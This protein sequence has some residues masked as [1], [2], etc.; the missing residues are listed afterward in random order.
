[1]RTPRRT[2]WPKV[3][4]IAVAGR[5]RVAIVVANYNTRRLIAQLIFSLYRILG[6]DQFD[7]LVVVDNASTDGSR[8]LL[9]GR[10]RARPAAS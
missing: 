9:A 10:R 8:Q 3:R 5:P 4:R 6:R 2:T 1:M 7:E